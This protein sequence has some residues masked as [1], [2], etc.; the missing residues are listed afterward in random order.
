MMVFNPQNDNIKIALAEWEP[1]VDEGYEKNNVVLPVES[2]MLVD[3]IM[4]S[5]ESQEFASVQITNSYR[6]YLEQCFFDCMHIIISFN[7]GVWI[8][9]ELLNESFDRTIMYSNPA[10][11]THQLL[12][13]ICTK[14]NLDSFLQGY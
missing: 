3:S 2:K 13:F 9:D 6:S 14:T 11:Y 8:F 7:D 5:L 4:N 10:F 12:S 1:K